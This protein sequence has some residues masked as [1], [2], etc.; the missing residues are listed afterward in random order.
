MAGVPPFR[1]RRPAPPAHRWARP[2]LRSRDLGGRSCRGVHLG[3]AGITGSLRS[4]PGGGGTAAAADRE[5]RDGGPGGPLAGR[6]VPRLREHGVGERRCLRRALPSGSHREALGRASDHFG[7]RR[8]PAA[9]LLARRPSDR[10]L[11]RPRHAAGQRSPAAV[12]ADEAGR[13]LRDGGRWLGGGSPAHPDPGMGRIPGLVARRR[14]DLLLLGAGERSFG[15]GL[16]RESGAS[17]GATAGVTGTAPGTAPEPSRGS[18]P[19]LG[20]HPGR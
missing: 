8:R 13:H 7:S 5:R 16:R 10:L 12:R 17:R 3:A 11:Q 1:P 18:V 6:S 9:G 20:R 15:P 19:D 14:R 2:E 4:G